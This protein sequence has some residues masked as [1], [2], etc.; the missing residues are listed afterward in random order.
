MITK[1]QHTDGRKLQIGSVIVQKFNGADGVV[2]LAFGRVTCINQNQDGCFSVEADV[3]RQGIHGYGEDWDKRHSGLLS[4]LDGGTQCSLWIST[5]AD[6]GEEAIQFQAGNLWQ[7]SASLGRWAS[8][9]AIAFSSCHG[10]PT[11]H[12]RSDHGWAAQ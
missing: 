4:D 11:G 9:E 2:R 7:L 3:F 6:S 12:G 1:I 8:P 10:G 5:D